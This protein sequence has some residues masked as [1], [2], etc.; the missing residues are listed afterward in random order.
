MNMHRSTGLVYRSRPPYEV[1]A[2]KWVSYDE[3]LEIRLVEEMLELH[4]NSGQFL[5]YLA[6]LDWNYDSTF[7]MFLDMGHFLS[8]TWLSG[9]QSQPCTA[10]RDRT[11]VC[12]DR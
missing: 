5:T 7:Q 9:L 10:D 12:R 2:S 4:Y 11:G 6:V 3:M 8:G 1:M